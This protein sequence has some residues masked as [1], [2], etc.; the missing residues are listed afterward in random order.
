MFM[1]RIISSTEV[2]ADANRWNYEWE[3]VVLTNG[4]D[5]VPSGISSSEGDGDELTAINLVEWEN[6]SGPN[7][8]V[9]PGVNMGGLDY[10]DGFDI[11]PISPSTIIF[12][13]N[14]TNGIEDQRQA[15]FSLA[16]AHDGTCD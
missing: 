12:M 5:F 11:Q 10:P 3:Q 6:P 7:A 9:H 1:G 14:V 4:T 2:S 13:R 16:N 15:V 8:L